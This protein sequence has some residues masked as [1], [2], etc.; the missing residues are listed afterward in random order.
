MEKTKVYVDVIAYFTSEGKLIP[1][2]LKWTDG[3]KYEVDK[4]L[5]VRRAASLK[6]GGVGTRYT[7]LIHGQQKHLYYEDN[8]KWFVEAK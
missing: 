1:V 4:V 5:D 6:A 7:C 8:F 2:C 3:R